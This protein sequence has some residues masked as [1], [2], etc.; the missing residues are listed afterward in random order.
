MSWVSTVPYV[1]DG[2]E[3]SAVVIDRPL[4]AL[5]E[6]TEW[7]KARL[8]ALTNKAAVVAQAMRVAQTVV[9]GDLVYF[10]AINLQY[11]KA[12]AE[13]SSIL[14]PEGDLQPGARAFV[15]GLVL[16]K[17]NAGMADIL[18]LGDWTDSA[19]ITAVFGASPEAGVYHLSATSPGDVT[20]TPPSLKCQVLTYEGGD[21]LSL[22]I[23]GHPQP[24]HIHR[25][26]EMVEAWLEPTDPEFTDMTVPVGAVKGYDVPADNDLSNLFVS[27]PGQLLLFAKL[28][29]ADHDLVML[30]PALYIVNRYG[31]WWMSGAVAPTA[32]Y[33]MRAFAYSPMSYDEPVVRAIRSATPESL[34]VTAAAGVATLTELP[35]TQSALTPSPSAVSSISGRLQQ[36]TPVISGLLAGP[37]AHV[38]NFT[39]GRAVVSLESLVD[40]LL[41]AD[42]YNLNNAVEDSSGDWISVMLPRGRNSSLTGRVPL[43]RLPTGV[44]YDVTVFAWIAGSAGQTGLSVSA[45]L[46]ES[47]RSAGLKPITGPTLSTTLSGAGSDSSQA[48]HRETTE[49]LDLTGHT[50]SE[51]SLFVTLSSAGAVD[52][53]IIGFGVIV[54]VIG[55]QALVDPMQ[56]GL[57]ARVVIPSGYSGAI[58]QSLTLPETGGASWEYTMRVGSAQRSGFV[59]G[60]VALGGDI[61]YADAPSTADAGSGGTTSVLLS[62][63]YVPTAG[64]VPGVIRLLC[65]NNSANPAILTVYGILLDTTEA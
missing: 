35:F 43:P 9:V 30:D 61:R 13:W 24:N 29:A 49:T 44:N 36:M 41:D 15:K 47:P 31:I 14:G 37:G 34:T 45:M 40:A 19:L 27:Y 8:D 52:V 59:Q 64:D 62:V 2:E 53:R 65:T 12:L 5:A 16:A 54:S 28:G 25:Q 63:D 33:D 50:A 38:A 46:T 18:R 39:N 7:L 26:Y 11:D 23:I 17:Q 22:H 57:S 58:V 3:G 21:T 32:F 48:Y 20:L 1:A 6:R 51:G 4:H 55:T 56:Q 60:T 42:I 10:D